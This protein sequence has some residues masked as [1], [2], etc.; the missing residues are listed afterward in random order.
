MSWLSTKTLLDK[1]TR[2][3]DLKTRSAFYGIYPIDKLPDFI[4]HLPIFIIIN[5]HTHNL[6][7]EHWKCVF[8][9]ENK[10][11]EVFDPLAYPMSNILIRW[12]NRFCRRWKVNR[13]SYQQPMTATCGA[14]VLYYLLTRLNSRSLENVSSLFSH[15]LYKNERHIRMFYR[16]LK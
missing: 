10:R 14:F 7:G 11:G 5:T 6:P 4:P 15:M 8:I 1:V 16:T 13:K 3:G 2:N 12:M 9:D